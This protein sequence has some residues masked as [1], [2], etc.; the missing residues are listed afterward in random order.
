[1]QDFPNLFDHQ[2]LLSQSFW[3]S[4]PWDFGNEYNTLAYI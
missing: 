2:T 3:N 1:M 4:D